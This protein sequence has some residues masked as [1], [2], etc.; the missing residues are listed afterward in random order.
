MIKRVKRNINTSKNCLKSFIALAD[1]MNLPK[2]T[3]FSFEMEKER[4][5]NRESYL[6]HKHLYDKHVKLEARK[7]ANKE[8]KE[9]IPI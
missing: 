5:R 2:E 7:R 9:L 4:E 8:A 1:V 6:A 3:I